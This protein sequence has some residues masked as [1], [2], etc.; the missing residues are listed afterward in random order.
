MSEANIS[1]K[2][3]LGR[4]AMRREGKYWNAYWSP[5][6]DNLDD[7]YLIGSIMMVLVEENLELKATFMATMKKAFEAI[8]AQSVGGNVEWG[9]EKTAPE[10][11]RAGHA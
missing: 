5:S 8:I 2:N 7:A 3:G 6:T 1:T 9:P 11:E 10:S 4:L